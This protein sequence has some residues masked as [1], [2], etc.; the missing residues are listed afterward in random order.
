MSEPENAFDDLI[1]DLSALI[2]VFVGRTRVNRERDGLRVDFLRDIPE[3][4]R[5]VLVDRVIIPPVAAFE[6]RDQLDE[7]LR[8][9]S[10]WYMPEDRDD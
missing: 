8:S 1:P 4:V 2:G 9:Y 10:E 6:L 5:P 7:A 3:A